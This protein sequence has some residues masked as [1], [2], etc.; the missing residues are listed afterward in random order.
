M[1]KKQKERKKKEK[2]RDSKK[3]VL[4]RRET[5]RKKA[6]AVRQE[7]VQQEKQEKKWQKDYED[8]ISSMP[9]QFEGMDPEEKDKEIKRR[10]ERNMQLLE[11]LEKEYM[12][13]QARKKEINDNLEAAGY[14]TMQE[15]LDALQDHTLQ[16][17]DF[18]P[19]EIEKIKNLNSDVSF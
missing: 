15:K 11:E 16:Q 8:A 18:S 19:E 2:E 1:K 12:E 4:K 17:Q 9:N 7:Q 13:E 3:K 10:L 6:K 14:V 5:I